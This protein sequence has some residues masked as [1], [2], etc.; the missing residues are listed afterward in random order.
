MLTLSS[1]I[2]EDAT[3]PNIHRKCFV[4]DTST[5][6]QEAVDAGFAELVGVN[7]K[8]VM[9]RI[10]DWIENDWS[11]PN[12]KSPFGDGNAA[13]KTVEILQDAGYC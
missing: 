9:K 5:E 4:L 12:R 8:K 13:E 6:R 10:W 2:Q 1:G 3:A 11:V 7:P